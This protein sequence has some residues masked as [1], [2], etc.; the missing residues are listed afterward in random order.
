[1]ENQAI[2]QGYPLASPIS[3]SV[4]ILNKLQLQPT[5]L[6]LHPYIFTHKS[7]Q[8]RMFPNM[9][10]NL[11]KISIPSSELQSF[12]SFQPNSEPGDSCAKILRITSCISSSYL[13]SY[14]FSICLIVCLSV[15]RI[16]FEADEWRLQ[17]QVYEDLKTKYT[18][19]LIFSFQSN[20]ASVLDA[21]CTHF[22][23]SIYRI[24]C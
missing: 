8:H 22:L 21:C 10:L 16:Y 4:Q 3:I 18:R 6:H 19:T 11:S 5:I 9:P 20:E 14:Y 12:V 24:A 23:V 1:M 15:R 2:L 7:T 17:D 13:Y